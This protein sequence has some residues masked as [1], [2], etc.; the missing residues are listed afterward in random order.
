MS[1]RERVDFGRVPILPTSRRRRKIREGVVNTYNFFKGERLAQVGFG[2]LGFYMLLAIFAPLIAPYNPTETHRGEAGSVLRI[3][4]PMDGHLLG[5]SQYGQDLLSQVIWGSRTSLFVGFLAAFIAVFVGMNVALISAYYGGWIDDI[6]MRVV[7][8]AYGLPFLPFV[9][10]L[11]FI[12]EA[13]LINMSFAIAV[14]LWRDTAR[15]VRSEVLTQKQRPYVEAA[16]MVGAG[17]FR[18]MYRHILPNVIPLVVL[19][20]SFA[21][22][23]A[24]IFEASVAFLGFSDPSI[25]SWGQMLFMSYTVG[26]ISY[27]WWWVVPPGVSIMLTVAAVFFIG[28]SI[29]KVANPE[30]RF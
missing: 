10:V 21:V 9:L 25:F 4:G 16:K 13:N 12:F 27:A 15:V 11:V 30:L 22:A 14:L 2:I 17:D 24:I 28:R 7:D 19:Y 20:L 26:A 29:E 1:L 8:I 5:T 3:E 6:L 18:V 23:Y